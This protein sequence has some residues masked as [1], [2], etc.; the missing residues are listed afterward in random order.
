MIGNECR[1][2]FVV[3][4]GTVPAEGEAVDT[5]DGRT[6]EE[7]GMRPGVRSEMRG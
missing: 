2:P 5:A 4:S 7:I 1:P 3:L 6:E